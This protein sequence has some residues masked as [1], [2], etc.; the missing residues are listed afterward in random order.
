MAAKPLRNTDEERRCPTCEGAGELTVAHWS[1]NPELEEPSLCPNEDCVAGW[2][3]FRPVDPLLVLAYQRRSMRRTG[4]A[5]FYRDARAAA[6]QP[7]R[8]SG[9]AP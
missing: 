3:R 4:Y 9:G 8:L 5:H 7:V 2:I 1:G 6:M